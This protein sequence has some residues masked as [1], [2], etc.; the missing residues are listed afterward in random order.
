MKHLREFP[1]PPNLDRNEGIQAMRHE[2]DSHNLYPPIFITYPV[3]E[4]SVNVILLNELRP[5]EWEKVRQYLE[6]N[7]YIDSLK[8]EKLPE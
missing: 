2:M 5:S 3:Y 7:K 1:T 8:Q 6:S 4:D